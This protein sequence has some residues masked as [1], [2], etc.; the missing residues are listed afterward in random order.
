MARLGTRILRHFGMQVKPCSPVSFF[1]QPVHFLHI[2][3]TAGTQIG[4]VIH[5]V[6][7]S[8]RRLE[9]VKHGHGVT[10]VS[11]PKEEPYFF[12]MRNPI[13]RFKSGFYSRKRMGRPRL[14]NPWSEHEARLFAEF[15]HANDL[16]EAL[17]EDGRRGQRALAGM[18]SIGHLGSGQIDW[19][20]K[21]GDI[22]EIRPPV[23]IIRQD[24]L[25]ADVETLLERLGI[26][27]R[28]TLLD[29]PVKAHANDYSGIP[30]LS[31]RA[32]AALRHW[33]AADFVFHA[34]CE[35]WLEERALSFGPSASRPQDRLLV[36]SDPGEMEFDA[37]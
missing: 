32:V 29:D 26:D 1:S 15:E 21:A 22:F 23:W 12:G 34:Q 8:Q 33:H 19:F 11:L 36:A 25:A 10:L 9:I 20:K 6:N 35:Q 17:F 14:N 16:A 18:L 13:A 2:G 7:A 28:V 30:E 27:L 3:K 31:E 37:V 24:R 4:H 5:Q